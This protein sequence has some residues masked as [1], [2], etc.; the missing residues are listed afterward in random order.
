MITNKEHNNWLHVD[1]FPFTNVLSYKWFLN[2]SQLHSLEPELKQHLSVLGWK[3]QN[4]EYRIKQNN[5]L[6]EITIKHKTDNMSLEET[7]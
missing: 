6:D 4:T 5:V 7:V 1:I 3:L 2:F